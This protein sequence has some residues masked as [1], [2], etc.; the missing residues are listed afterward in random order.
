[1][2]HAPLLGLVLAPIACAGTQTPI[3]SPVTIDLQAATPA[4]TQAAAPLE[5]APTSPP[6]ETEVGVVGVVGSSA[7]DDVAA[8]GSMWGDSIGESF[9]AGGLGLSGVGQGGAHGTSG[10]G[11]TGTLGR[12][13]GTPGHGGP[14]VAAG[15]TTITGRL[16]PEVI[17]R[18][19]RANHGRFRL[20]YERGLAV[21]PRLEGRVVVD[22]TIAADG[23]IASVSSRDS[24][25]ASKDVATCVA[26]AFL[27]ISFPQPEGGLVHVSY[28]IVFNL[29][30]ASPGA[31]PAAPPVTPKPKA[32]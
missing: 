7:G 13:A 16:P 20:C 11:A 15:A 25:L 28:P 14:S 4:S 22:F 31:A 8:K 10:P 29:G 5:P 9:G 32:R 2:K 6:D 27:S 1:M 30:D 24:T 26:N 12:G 3:G 19:V 18:I 21:A 17:Q 23:S